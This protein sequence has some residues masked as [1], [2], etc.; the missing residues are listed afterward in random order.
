MRRLKSSLPLQQRQVDEA[1]RGLAGR[2]QHEL[3]EVVEHGR[4]RLGAV[5]H[6]AAR[7]RQHALPR[8]A[9]PKIQI[10]L[11]RV[12]DA[13]HGQI[14]RVVFQC[15][16]VGFA[17]LRDGCAVGRRIQREGAVGEGEAAVVVRGLG[18][19]RAAA[20]C[21]DDDPCIDV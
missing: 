12:G 9:I 1:A 17:E 20:Q 4:E 13:G 21:G 8:G 6:A 15:Q 11:G 2:G 3:G 19:G 5:V 7:A 16:R 10:E 18:R 14:S